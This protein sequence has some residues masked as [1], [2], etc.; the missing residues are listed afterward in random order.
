MT[1]EKKDIKGHGID[2]FKLL[3]AM[4]G[5]LALLLGGMKICGAPWDPPIAAARDDIRVSRE[6][7]HRILRKEAKEAH[8][9][10]EEDAKEHKSEI[11]E[12]FKDM[13]RQINSMYRWEREDRRGQ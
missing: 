9:E 12:D 8:K 11:K 1:S 2:F 3:A 5:T 4:S 10:I 13:K 7:T 6:A